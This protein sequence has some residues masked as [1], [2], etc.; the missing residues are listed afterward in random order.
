MANNQIDYKGKKV[1]VTGAASGMGESVVNQL[2]ELGAEIYAMDIREVKGPVKEYIPLNLGD[3]TSIDS[4]VAKLPEQIDCVFSC[5][6]IAGTTYLGKTFTPLEVVTI[7][8]IGTR[9]FV[10]SLVPRL[11]EGSGIVLVSSIA[12]MNWRTKIE[13]YKEFLGIT[14]FKDAQDFVVAHENDPLFIAGPSQINKPYS[15]SKECIIIYSAMRSWDLAEKKIRINTVS[16][17]A[18]Q[19]PM[20]DDF[21]EIVGKERGG[22]MNVS[23]A[24]SESIPDQQA[25]VMLM[26]NSEMA[27]YVSGQ[28][29]QVDF[30]Y[31]MGV[32]MGRMKPLML[33][34]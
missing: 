12:G 22:K 15:F 24:G 33:K 13:D 32:Q 16:P 4:A 21:L 2:A 10:E 30:A 17:G 8:F 11:H 20:H 34:S 19:T 23:P 25:S 31:A 5:A 29:V 1:V 28:D 18:T 6:G 27:D 9:Y 26:L 3:K 14:D 7:N